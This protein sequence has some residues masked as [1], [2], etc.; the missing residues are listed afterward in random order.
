[1]CGSK[2]ITIIIELIT[3]FNVSPKKLI[4]NPLFIIEMS[5]YIQ[6]TI[7]IPKFNNKA[8]WEEFS[9]SLIFSI[10]L[11]VSFYKSSSSF[12]IVFI[13]ITNTVT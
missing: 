3:L 5:R 11:S 2:I 12:F 4:N 8:D 9:F 7:V 6:H 13:D 1:M 10:S